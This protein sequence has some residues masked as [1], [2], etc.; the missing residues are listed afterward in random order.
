MKV[1]FTEPALDDLD[2]IR[3][4]LQA[5]Y[6]GIAASVEKRLRIIV[7]GRVNRRPESAPSVDERPGVRVALLVRYGLRGIAGT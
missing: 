7:V 6:P 2:E 5:H 3:R 1:V 4:R